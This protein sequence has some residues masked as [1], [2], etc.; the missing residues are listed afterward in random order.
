LAR[1][2]VRSEEEGRE[3]GR[4]ERHAGVLAGG[5]QE[6]PVIPWLTDRTRGIPRRTL[7]VNNAG[8]N[9]K[10]EKQKRN[11]KSVKSSGIVRTIRD[12]SE[13][14]GQKIIGRRVAVGSALFVRSGVGGELAL[15]NEP[16]SDIG[17]AGLFGPLIQKNS[18]FFAQ[19]RGVREAR[20]FVRLQS[21]ARGGEKELPGPRGA[22]LRHGNLR[23]RLLP[24]CD[25][26]ITSTVIHNESDIFW[27]CL[28]KSVENQENAVSCCSGCAGDY[29]DPDWTAWELDV[30]EEEEDT[31]SATNGLGEDGSRET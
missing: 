27:V 10:N 16:T 21:I 25:K 11:E 18:D 30:E 12:G 2:L 23:G 8:A 26:D 13:R 24:K 7:A 28:W 3:G 20:E 14:I 17:S 22:G 6:G 15:V 31:D 5:T 9:Y 4:G 19:I 1:W 29:E